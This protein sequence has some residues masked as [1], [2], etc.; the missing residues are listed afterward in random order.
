[1]MTGSHGNAAKNGTPGPRIA[2]APAEALP[3]PV[4]TPPANGERGG[5]SHSLVAQAVRVLL[6]PECQPY[7]D[8][9]EELTHA[10]AAE[11]C[12]AAGGE[13]GPTCL[14]FLYNAALEEAAG[15][16]LL[17]EALSL[18]SSG[19]IEA[20]GEVGTIA[21]QGSRMLQAAKQH[22]L[23]SWEVAMR[24]GAARQKADGGG[25]PLDAG[26]LAR[27]AEE[28]TARRRAGKPIEAPAEEG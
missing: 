14:A 9:A 2:Q 26:A 17:D 18:Q 4:D 10:I 20:L 13:L 22:R 6:A 16:Y 11:H 24:L 7:R 8:V 21:S 12:A 3:P 1:M 5:A 15:R 19:K 25:R 23:A 27:Q 28:R